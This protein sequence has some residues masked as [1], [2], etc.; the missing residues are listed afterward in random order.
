MAAKRLYAPSITINSVE[1]KCKARSV[2]LE[3]GEH[4]NYCEQEWRFIAE[5]EIGY[6]TAESQT[7]LRALQ[8]TVVAVVLKPEDAVVS[9][10][11]PSATFNVRIPAIPF[12]TAASKGDR[13]TFTLDVPTEAAPAFAV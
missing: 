9:A 1:Y 5:I 10:T 8:D 6:G 7:L 13:M 2:A 12:I 4:I 3:P 11:N